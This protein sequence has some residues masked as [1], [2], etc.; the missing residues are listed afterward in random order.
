MKILVVYFSR[1]G[2]TERMAKA[3]ARRCDADV[4]QIR[5]A[6]GGDSWLRG[7]RSCW[8]AMT[9]ANPPIVRPTRNPARYELVI[10]GAPVGRLGIAP[11]V[12]TYVEMCRE[13]F[14]QV[15]FFCAEGGTV[16][17]RGFAELGR[18]CGQ[19]P[20]AT[21]DVDRKGLPPVAHQRGLT[22]FM[23]SMRL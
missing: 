22:D 15:A 18:L 16:G 20:V 2:H 10:I 7:W 6:A 21:F 12:R 4:E 3:I 19:Q 11:P 1:D 8:Q 5:E 13:R 23:D 14:S 9:H 17:Q